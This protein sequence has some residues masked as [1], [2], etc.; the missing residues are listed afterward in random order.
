M[1]RQDLILCQHA[2]DRPTQSRPSQFGGHDS[3]YMVHRKVRAHT[4][5]D[6]PILDV[7]AKGDDLSRHV[8]AWD[9]VTLLTK[10]VDA[11]GDYEVA[12]LGVSISSG[13]A[14]KRG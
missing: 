8:G 5:T 2:V 7:L 9:Q 3:K 12:V 10:P 4:I 14:M 11:L 1:C 13:H 6:G